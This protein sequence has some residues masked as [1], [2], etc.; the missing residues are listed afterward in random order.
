MKQAIKINIALI[1]LL[2]VVSCKQKETTDKWDDTVHSGIIQIACDE[3]FKSLIEKE[4]QVFEGHFPQAVIFPIYTSETEAI[5]LL[6]SDSVRFA[7][8]TRDLYA[9]E[10]LKLDSLQMTARKQLVA[11]DGVAMI[12]NTLNK[13]SLLSIPQLKRILAGE[14][15]EWSQI[16]SSSPLGTIRLLVDSKESGILRYVMDSIADKNRLTTNIYSLKNYNEVIEKVCEM[17]NAAGFVSLNALNTLPGAEQRKIRLLRLSETE[18]A[19]LKN[20]YLPY[21]GDLMQSNYPFWRPVYV[22]LSDPK[23]GLSTGLSVF[24]GLEVGQKII[25]QEGLLPVTDP[26][27]RE[28]RVID[29]YPK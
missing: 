7:L 12:I 10:K 18:P 28:I 15:T 4:I 17:P 29:A 2:S 13:D 16:H 26:Q 5:R 1:F 9:K 22:L 25:M 14:I 23:S 19:T 8:T 6:T 20:S 11:F 3:N 21:A 27:N 24:L